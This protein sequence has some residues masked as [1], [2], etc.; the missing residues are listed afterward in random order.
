MWRDAAKAP[1]AAEALKLI[2]KDLVKMG[3]CDRIITE[4]LGGAHRDP[5]ATADRLG[6]VVAEEL[7][8]L[9]Q[10]PPEDFLERRIQ[11]YANIGL[12]LND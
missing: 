5:Q 4:P 11:R 10:D 2:P 1:V 7:D 8:R 9:T 6:E 12:V 3:V